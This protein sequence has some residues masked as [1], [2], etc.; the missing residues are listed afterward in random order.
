MNCLLSS[1]T[2]DSEFNAPKGV[3]YLLPNNTNALSI[4]GPLIASV[5]T[6]FLKAEKLGYVYGKEILVLPYLWH[7]S[8]QR[9]PFV[10]NFQSCIEKLSTNN[11]NQ[12]VS[13]V[14]NSEGTLASNYGILSYF[15]F[16]LFHFFSIILF[17]IFL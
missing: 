8:L 15:N 7:I 6:F 4:L 11:G 9:Q 2:I 16:F 3:S 1:L 12:K 14:A 10:Q 13:I 5:S 17:F